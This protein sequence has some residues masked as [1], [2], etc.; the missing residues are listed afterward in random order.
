MSVM[1]KQTRFLDLQMADLR[2]V[3][4]ECVEVDEAGTDGGVFMVEVGGE[5]GSALGVDG[6]LEGANPVETPKGVG[7]GLR[8]SGFAQADGAV[9]LFETVHMLLVCSG[10]V[11][12][13]ENRVAG[14]AGFDGVQRRFGFAFGRSRAGAELGI[15]AVRGELGGRR[16]RDN[17][18]C[19]FRLRRAEVFG[20]RECTVLLLQKLLLFALGGAA[21]GA[22]CH[23]V[24]EVRFSRLHRSMRSG[25]NELCDLE[26]SG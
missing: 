2:F 15:G 22:G 21:D 23:T 20:Y 24:L 10:V 7:D 3:G 6:H 25:E 4:A 8:E 16:F 13:K 12:G 14:E 11:A 17:F 9:F 19:E 18:G 26:Q 1:A 5:L